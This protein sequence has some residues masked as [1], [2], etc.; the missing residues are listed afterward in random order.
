[1]KQM[2]YD[3]GRGLSLEHVNKALFYG[4]KLVLPS[5]RE[6]AIPQYT[7]RLDNS[8]CMVEYLARCLIESRPSFPRS[9]APHE[10]TV[11]P[12]R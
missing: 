3:R 5:E 7:E 10:R 11:G 9:H 1:M 8:P 4:K 2:C 6:I 12:S